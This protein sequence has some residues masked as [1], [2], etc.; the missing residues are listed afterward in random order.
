[1][2]AQLASALVAAT[3]VG[4]SS[5]APAAGDVDFSRDG[6]TWTSRL[7]AP[8]FDPAVRWVPG[9]RRTA[10]F[11]VRNRGPVGA[12]M[13]VQARVVGDLAHRGDIALRARTRGADWVD[14]RAR[15][16]VGPGA[17]GPAVERGAA[18]RVDVEAAFDPAATNRTQEE[19]LVLDVV[20]TLAADAAA[21]PASALP[22]TGTVVPPWLL[23]LAASSLLLGAHL[24]RRRGRELR[25]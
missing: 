21:P 14:L 6:T 22:S 7:D 10:S 5:P 1:M 3:L 8:L 12:V 20:V 15:R 9:D 25:G 2:S 16:S 19:D 11:W 24:L 17:R 4:L 23:G 18:A 13:H